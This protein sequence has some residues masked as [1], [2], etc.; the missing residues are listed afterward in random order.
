MK[1][2]D[3]KNE[4][5]TCVL[6]RPAEN[7]KEYFSKDEVKMSERRFERLKPTLSLSKLF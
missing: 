6:R 2:F 4:V 3:L 1:N 7:K 5:N